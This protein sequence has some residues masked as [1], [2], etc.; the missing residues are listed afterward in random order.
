[1]SRRVSVLALVLFN[2][3]IDE[4]DSGI[5]C[6]LSKSVDNTML[7]D[8]VNTPEGWDARLPELW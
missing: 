7:W 2:I 4:T 8:V 3:F 5:E 1:M 6:T